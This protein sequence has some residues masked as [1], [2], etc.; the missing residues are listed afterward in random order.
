MAGLLG[1]LR[2]TGLGSAQDRFG[3]A[4]NEPE[5]GLITDRVVGKV[6]AFPVQVNTVAIHAGL[7]LYGVG[8]ALG[9]AQAAN[10]AA[11]QRHVPGLGRGGSHA[12][13]GQ[14]RAAAA[15]GSHGVAE[16]K[17][18]GHVAGRIGVGNVA[19]DDALPF[20]THDQGFR[21]E[22]QAIGHSCEHGAS[23]K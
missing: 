14:L 7:G 17:V 13:A 8:Q 9:A 22:V 20:G 2:L 1:W 23:G 21:V 15:G 19:G 18:A 12:R 6:G 11:R 10:G 3:I 5:G 16:I 4:V